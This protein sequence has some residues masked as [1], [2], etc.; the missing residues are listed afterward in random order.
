VVLSEKED[1]C[2]G[3]TGWG[4]IDVV[5]SSS[6]NYSG[7]KANSS[8]LLL[9]CPSNISLSAFLLVKLLRSCESRT[10]KF[11][12]NTTILSWLYNVHGSS[13]SGGKDGTTTTTATTTTAEDPYGILFEIRTQPISPLL[14]E[15]DIITGCVVSVPPPGSS[16]SS[17]GRSSTHHMSLEHDVHLL[18]SVQEHRTTLG[19]TATIGI[20]RNI[21]N[22]AVTEHNTSTFHSYP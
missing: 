17:S 16:S 8:P 2:N 4:R 13:K 21:N 15:R 9:P 7:R 1:V 11:M 5:S 6:L 10:I 3:P 20:Y 18:E 22:S 12:Y 19:V 14:D